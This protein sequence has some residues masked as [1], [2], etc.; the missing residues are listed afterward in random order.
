MNIGAFVS[1]ALVFLAAR[2]EDIPLAEWIFGNS[3]S[4]IAI[5]SALLSLFLFWFLLH[6]RKTWWVRIIAAFQVTM[7]LVAVTYSHFPNIM[8]LRNGGNISL[9][10]AA[11]SSTITALGWALVIGSAFILPA[12]FY[13]IYSFD[14]KEVNTSP[15]K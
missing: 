9:M 2:T 12:F 7:I 5:I 1:G 15:D 11:N 13:L 10:D 3:I 6:K 8:L 14:E 4:A